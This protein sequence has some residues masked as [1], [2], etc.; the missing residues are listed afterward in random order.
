MKVEQLLEVFSKLDPT[1][2]IKF[3]NGK[4]WDKQTM[5]VNVITEIGNCYILQWE[6]HPHCTL[7]DM[8]ENEKLVW[9][10]PNCREPEYVRKYFPDYTDI[11]QE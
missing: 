10:N 4:G 7:E 11:T 9:Y 2:R 8:K 1:K 6:C 3:Q 5:A